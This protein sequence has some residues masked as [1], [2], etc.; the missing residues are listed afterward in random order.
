MFQHLVESLPRRMEAVI[1]EK[2]GK[3]HIT[4]DSTIH[5][6]DEPLSRTDKPA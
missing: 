1:A 5:G 6:L 3:L 2:V 4:P